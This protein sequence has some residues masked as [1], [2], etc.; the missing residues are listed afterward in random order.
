MTDQDQRRVTLTRDSMGRYTVRN[1][2]GGSVTTSSGTDELSP[3]ELL[4]AGIAG[5]TAVDVDTVTSRRAEPESFEIEVTADKVKDEHGNHLKD[6]EVT[7]RVRFPDDEGGEAARTILP[8]LVRRS[9]EEFCTV[10]RTIMLGA[11]VT[12]RLE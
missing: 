12:S 3:V 10:S 4:L 5:C 7:F 2:R 9:H 8:S 11:E 1:D 6:I